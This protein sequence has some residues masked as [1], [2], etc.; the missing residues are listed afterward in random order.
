M[1]EVIYLTYEI[2]NTIRIYILRVY[3]IYIIYIRVREHFIY[4]YEFVI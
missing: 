1:D 2:Y 4:I 3:F